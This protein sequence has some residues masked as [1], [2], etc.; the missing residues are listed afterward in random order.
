MPTSA[1]AAN[2]NEYISTAQPAHKPTIK[3]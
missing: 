2:Q 3:S 1:T